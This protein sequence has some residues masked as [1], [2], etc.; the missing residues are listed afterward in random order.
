MAWPVVGIAA[1]RFSI[2]SYEFYKILHLI[3]VILVFLSFGGLIVRGFA[4]DE[5]PGVRRLGAITNGVG[6]LLIL[7]GGF[8]IVAK[9]RL[10]FPAWVV[11]KMIIWLVLGGMIAMINRFPKKGHVLWWVTAL[12]GAAAVVLAVVKPG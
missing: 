4:G 2:M 6:L 1:R 5:N 11:G 8:G 7:V 10:G 9:L 3:G 12:L